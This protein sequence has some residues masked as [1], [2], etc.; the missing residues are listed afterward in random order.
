[1]DLLH[2]SIVVWSVT[3]DFPWLDV[4]QSYK[5][6]HDEVDM[7]HESI[8][9][10]HAKL[11]SNWHIYEMMSLKRSFGPLA[12]LTPYDSWLNRSCSGSQLSGIR[13][14]CPAHRNWDLRIVST[15]GRHA[16][17]R[18]LMLVRLSD[19]WMCKMVQRHL[20]WKHSSW[21]M[22]RWR[23]RFL[24]HTAEQEEQEPCK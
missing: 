21:V 4:Q 5:P 18:T 16:F 6:F 14:T 15:D 12:G 13:T 8:R 9:N 1:M 3:R 2:H 24:C 20:C 19:Q 10:W 22:W 11:I 7:S 23:S 17:S